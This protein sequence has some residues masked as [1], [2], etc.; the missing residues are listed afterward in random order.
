M[1]KQ[2]LD[3]VRL[4]PEFQMFFHKSWLKKIRKTLGSKCTFLSFSKKRNGKN[5]EN[6]ILVNLKNTSGG[7]DKI[8][9]KLQVTPNQLTDSDYSTFLSMLIKGDYEQRSTESLQPTA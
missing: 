9:Y 5:E 4:L 6:F 8:K 7:V 1:T 3:K 2:E